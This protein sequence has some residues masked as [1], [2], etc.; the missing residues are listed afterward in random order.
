MPVKFNHT[1]VYARDSRA[2][3]AFLAELLGLSGPTRWGPFHVVTT[4]NDANV[5]FMNADGDITPQHYAFLVGETDFEE[6]F[7]RIRDRGLRYWA[8]P[9]QTTEGDI[10][11]HDGGRGLYFEDPDG[12]L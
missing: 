4:D 11:R 12:H 1:I 8:D 7:K 3:A 5:D 2:S 10:N 6:I 9:A